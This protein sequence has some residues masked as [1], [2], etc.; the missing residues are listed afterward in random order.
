MTQEITHLQLLFFTQLII[1][2]LWDEGGTAGEVYSL[3]QIPSNKTG[4]TLLPT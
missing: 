4:T 3:R 2:W 1:R